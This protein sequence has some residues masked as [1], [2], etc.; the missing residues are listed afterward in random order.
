M[1]DSCNPMNCSL[2]GSSVH[3]ILQARILEW[4]AISFSKKE[5]NLPGK[6]GDLRDAS[7][8]PG[9]GISPGG[10]HGNPLKYSCLGKPMD[11]GAWWATVHRVAQ[12]WRRLKRQHAGYARFVI[13]FL[14][15]SKHR[16]SA[17]T[18]SC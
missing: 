16:N 6:A 10:V 3:G 12:S 2:P 8:I 11:N 1:S 4:V 9:L 15:R 17:M 14:P 13:T 7:L 18:L 5:K